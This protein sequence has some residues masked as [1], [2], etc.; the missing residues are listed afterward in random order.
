MVHDYHRQVAISWK[1][2]VLSLDVEEKT[3]MMIQNLFY[4]ALPISWLKT[5]VLQIL[6]KE[7]G[8]ETLNSDKKKLQEM[9]SK[10]RSAILLITAAF[11]TFI[12]CTLNSWGHYH[13]LAKSKCFYLASFCETTMLFCFLYFVMNK[14]RGRSK[15]GVLQG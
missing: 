11:S 1:C 15:Q 8:G 7:F 14:Q 6:K 2:Q 12:S 3:G 4:N 10:S 13:F 9:A 5:E